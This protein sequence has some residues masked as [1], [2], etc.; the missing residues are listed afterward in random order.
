MDCAKILL[1]GRIQGVGNLWYKVHV[2]LIPLRQKNVDEHLI[3]S[4]AICSTGSW[5]FYRID[6]WSGLSLF[7]FDEVKASLIITIFIFISG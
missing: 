7:L 1:L 3:I 5:Q 4:L 2:L 6:L